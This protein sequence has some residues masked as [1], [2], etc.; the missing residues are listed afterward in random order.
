MRPQ[1]DSIESEE[2]IE[3]EE[4]PQKAK[5]KEPEPKA[6]YDDWGEVDF[7]RKNS[8]EK[9]EEK[10]PQGNSIIDAT[11]EKFGLP[12]MR[13]EKSKE[14]SKGKAHKEESITAKLMKNLP[15]Y[16]CLIDPK[17]CFPDDFFG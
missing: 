9:R 10:K 14:L 11:F 2:D 15:D 7:T 12:N 16:A 5:E 13:K 1:R 3:D 6:F 4:P 8:P 17:I